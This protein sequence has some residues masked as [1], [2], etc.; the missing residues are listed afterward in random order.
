MKDKRAATLKKQAI[1]TNRSLPVDR[2]EGVSLRHLLLRSNQVLLNVNP[3]PE[4]YREDIKFA[5][6]R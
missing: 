2:K 1:I 5:I 6:I 4:V 3:A